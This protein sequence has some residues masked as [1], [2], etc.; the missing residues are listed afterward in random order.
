MAADASY[1]STD[2]DDF[3]AGSTRVFELSDV[4]R[5]NTEVASALKQSIRDSGGAPKVGKVAVSVEK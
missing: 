2:E 4:F 5:G 3:E 1:S